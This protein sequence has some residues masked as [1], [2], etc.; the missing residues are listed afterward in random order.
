MLMMLMMMM[1]MMMMMK[2]VGMSCPEKHN[3]ATLR[4]GTTWA[5]K[6]KK[7]LTM[8]TLLFDNDYFQNETHNPQPH[9]HH[10]PHHHK[11]HQGDPFMQFSFRFSFLDIYLWTFYFWLLASPI[12][13]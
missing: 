1:M 4:L 7:H 6:K 12:S 10:H 8:W 3:Q 5:E 13:E 2:T 9:T 11:S